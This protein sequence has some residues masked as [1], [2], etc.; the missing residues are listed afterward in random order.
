M[1]KTQMET[2]SVSVNQVILKI[3]IHQPVNPAL[4]IVENVKAM[5]ISVWSAPK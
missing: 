1:K 2:A 5:Q 4:K 3:P